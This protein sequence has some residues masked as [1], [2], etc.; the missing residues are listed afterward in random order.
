MPDH[1]IVLKEVKPKAT[2]SLRQH[3]VNLDNI[4]FLFYTMAQVLRENGVQ[5]N[6]EPSVV[7]YHDVEVPGFSAEVELAIPVTKSPVNTIT[8]SPER[9]IYRNEL[10]G[11]KTM[12]C[13][14]HKGG[15]S[16]RLAAHIAAAQWMA[17]NG[18]RLS[19]PVR[20]VVHRHYGAAN[21][22]DNMIEIQFPV[23]RLAQ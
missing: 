1:D 9:A 21:D 7:I 8:L 12:A 23:K 18:Y 17:H 20:E 4:M 16:A 6:G 11:V 15:Y 3:I 13:T 5:S 10:P 14:L 22:A 19:G 2:M